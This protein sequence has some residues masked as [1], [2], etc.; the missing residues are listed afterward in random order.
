MNLL[1]TVS[2]AIGNNRI[3]TAN[4]NDRNWPT[5]DA[6]IKTNDES[7]LIRA[8]SLKDSVPITD[9]SDSQFE[10]NSGTLNNNFGWTPDFNET[11][12]C[13]ENPCKC[14]NFNVEKTVG[15]LINRAKSIKKSVESPDYC[16]GRTL[17]ISDGKQ[18]KKRRFYEGD[19][20][21]VVSSDLANGYNVGY[22]IAR[23]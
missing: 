6:A 23:S 10:V 5:I 22:R 2:L 4:S 1:I 9:T 7:A 16:R 15:N 11:E 19:V 17:G 20:V 8:I 21:S 18:H 14:K 13:S 12:E 3:I